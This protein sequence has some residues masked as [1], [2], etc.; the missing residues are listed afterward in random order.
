MTCANDTT[1]PSFSSSH[2]TARLGCNDPL[3]QEL[4]AIK[5][6]MNAESGYSIE[7]LAE[8]ARQ[9]N[10]EETLTRLRQLVGH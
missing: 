1:Q 9:F 10:L 3:L 6:T 4:W 8:Q 2:N 5:A 7:K